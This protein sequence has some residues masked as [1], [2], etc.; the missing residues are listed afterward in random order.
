MFLTVAN[1]GGQVLNVLGSVS[2]TVL[3]SSSDIHQCYRHPVKKT[4]V[5]L[6]IDFNGTI[7]Y[8]IIVCVLYGLFVF[9]SA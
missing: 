9:H 5:V 1:Y 8:A 3:V 7:E 2:T 6:I 4:L